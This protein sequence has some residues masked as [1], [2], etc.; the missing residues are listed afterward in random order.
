[1]RCYNG[2]GT[3]DLIATTQANRFTIGSWQYVTA[4]YAETITGSLAY[5]QFYTNSGDSVFYID[6]VTRYNTVATDLYIRLQSDA[7]IIAADTDNKFFDTSGNPYTVNCA[8]TEPYYNTKL[9]Y[10][11]SQKLLI[12]Y[13]TDKYGNIFNAAHDFIEWNPITYLTTNVKTV[14]KDGTGDYLTIQAALTGIVDASA[15]KKYRIDIYDDWTVTA[16]VDYTADG[17][18]FHWLILK[19]YI[20]LNGIGASKIKLTCSIPD[21]S[22]DADTA[23][24]EPFSTKIGGFNNLEISMEN[25]RYAIHNDSSSL[26]YCYN[27]KVINYGCQGIVDYR[28]A[29]M[30]PAGS[31]FNGATIGEGSQNGARFWFY[32]T[33]IIGDYPYQ[34]HDNIDYTIGAITALSKVLLTGSVLDAAYIQN[35]GNSTISSKFIFNTCTLDGRI[36]FCGYVYKGGAAS[37]VDYLLQSI[38][39]LGADNTYVSYVNTYTLGGS[40][41]ITSATPAGSVTNVAGT[42][43]TAI[44]PTPDYA[45]NYATGR[46][47][48]GEWAA[49]T[50]L[51]LGVRLGDC[52]GVNKIL[53]MDIDTVGKTVTFNENFT[54]QNNAYVLAF[55]DAAL[56]GSGTSSLYQRAKDYTPTGL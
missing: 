46:A 41:R 37:G 28:V 14:K 1:M 44:M 19:D 7:G 35:I 23:A 3:V 27:C 34:S 47:E 6:D 40:L 49:N 51:K 16:K 30:L 10:N 33:E 20:Y 54:A 36:N 29:N 55:I 39:I 5:I 24:Y 18:Y 42:G 17:G 8:N 12:L 56:A 2:A 50:N 43:A 21:D 22:S 32:N 38:D 26:I 53:T 25:G 9:F 4:N 15:T 52:S 45:S 48:V 13:D 11:L 31:P